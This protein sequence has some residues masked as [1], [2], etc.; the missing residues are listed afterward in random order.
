MASLIKVKVT[1]MYFDGERRYRVGE[2]VD[3]PEKDLH[4]DCH[5]R[6]DGKEI[7]GSKLKKQVKPTVKKQLPGQGPSPKPPAPKDETDGEE[8]V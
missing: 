5:E 1:R 6:V 4:P 8:D 2:K 7:S 3:L